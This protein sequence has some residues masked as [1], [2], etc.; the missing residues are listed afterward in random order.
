MLR[1]YATFASA[2][3]AAATA[4][5][6][7][8]GDNALLRSVCVHGGLLR[9]PPAVARPLDNLIRFFRGVCAR[10]RGACVCLYLS[11]A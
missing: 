8:A 10:A 1:T 5:A 7:A 3:C 9:R 11:R 6:A 4:A 2:A